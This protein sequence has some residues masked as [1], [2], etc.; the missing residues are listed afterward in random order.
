M[1]KNQ[2][3]IVLLLFLTCFQVQAQGPQLPQ[4]CTGSKVRYGVA[5]FP[6][7]VFHWE[8]QGGTIIANDNDSV[9][10]QWGT[11]D[12]MGMLKVTEHTVTS[13][14]GTP[15]YAYVVVS[16]PKSL[17]VDEGSP[18][19]VGQTLNLLTTGNFKKYLWNTGETTKDIKAQQPGWYKIEAE[20]EG[21]CIIRDSVYVNSKPQVF[22]GNDTMVCEQIELNA[23][24]GSFYQW[25]NG[26][27][28]RTVPVKDEKKAQTFW[29]KVTDENG[30]VSSDT[31][32]IIPCK[33][34]QLAGI[35]NTFTPNGDASNPT[36]R[37]PGL[38]NFQNVSIE[39]YDRWGRSVFKSSHG[40]PEGGWDGTSNGKPLP[41]D[42]YYYIINLNNGTEPILGTVTIIR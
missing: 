1:M 31:I 32:N 36:W 15:V 10:V 13:C 33:G 18:V 30:C 3:I 27:V 25:S 35:P 24:D 28:S 37:I 39:I 38:E 7:S 22:L 42:S 20:D 34:L 21:G 9:D 29:V 19:C 23:G 14:V 11:A 6:Q 4:A 12:A 16:S 2:L 41:M 8:I 26:M 17:K 5:G 40:L